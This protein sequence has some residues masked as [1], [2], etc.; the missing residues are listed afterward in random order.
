MFSTEIYLYFSKKFGAEIDF[1]TTAPITPPT[2]YLYIH[3]KITELQACGL[4]YII[5]LCIIMI[6]IYSTPSL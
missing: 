1:R 3:A 2:I 5:I 6:F 4:F